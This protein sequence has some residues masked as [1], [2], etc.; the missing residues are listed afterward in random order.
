MSPATALLVIYL[1]IAGSADGMA[2]CWHPALPCCALY[3]MALWMRCK[4][5]LK[6]YTT[7]SH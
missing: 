3:T 4:I 1:A 2:F 5:L 7:R 6:L